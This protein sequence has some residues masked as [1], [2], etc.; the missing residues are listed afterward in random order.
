M[1][2]NRSIQRELSFKA[3]NKILFDSVKTD[4]FDITGYPGELTFLE[5]PEQRAPSATEYTLRA[6]G[7]FAD[8]WVPAGQTIETY[9]TDR[10]M[11]RNWLLGNRK[12]N[13]RMEAM[14]E[15]WKDLIASLYNLSLNPNWK[16]AVSY[17]PHLQ[18]ELE[19]LILLVLSADIRHR[20]LDLM[21]LVEDAE[22]EPGMPPGPGITWSPEFS[23][24]KNIPEL[25]GYT[26]DN[27]PTIFF[28]RV[29]L[30]Y[31]FRD[32]RTQTW[33]NR[34]KDWLSDY[35]QTFFSSTRKT[36]FSPLSGGNR[37][38]KDWSAARLKARAVHGINT[39]IAVAMPFDT[40]K[41]HGVRDVSF[42]RVNLMANP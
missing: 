6:L 42:V 11:V 15:A 33:L 38:L 19:E 2:F 40:K 39:R 30:S 24:Y 8:S 1:N 27:E 16:T 3:I 28:S 7:R 4:I 13:R 34:R 14:D 18:D 10:Q 23:Y 22:R 32:G 31:T 36:D 35:F 26:A 9:Q 25:T 29:S 41:V 12:F 37:V 21:A 5:V 17:A 20:S